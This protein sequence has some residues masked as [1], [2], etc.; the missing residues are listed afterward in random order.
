MENHTMLTDLYQLTMA[1]SYHGNNNQEEATFDMFIRKLPKDRNYLI[2]A[3]LEQVIEYL[4]NLHFTE[5]DIQYLREQQL[6][7]EDFLQ[8]LKKFKFEGEVYAVQEGTPIFDNEPIMRITAP[9]I[10]AQIVETFILNTI[11][12]QTMIA[13]KASRIVQTANPQKVVDFGLRRA[14][15][16]D[17]GMKAARASYIAGCVA[18]SNVKAGKQYSMPISGTMAHSYIMD[19]E[20]ELEAFR[21]YAKT[22]KNQPKALTLLIDTYD[23]IQGAKNAAIIAKELEKEGKKIS[24]VRLDSGDL[25]KLS[26][27]VRKILDEQGLNY[28]KIFASNDLNEYKIK[29]LQ[30]QG[31]KIDAYGVG[32][33]MATS[34]DHPALP[35][36]YKLAE[37][38]KNGKKI[39][40][41]KLSEDKNTMP[42]RK[43][44]YRLYSENGKML[45]DI[46][47]LETE[48]IEGEPLLQKVMQNGKRLQPKKSLGKIRSYCLQQVD[49]LPDELK[50]IDAK[51][52]YK[53][54]IAPGLQQ[55]TQELIK[56]YGG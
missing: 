8:Y 56:K 34:K 44:A 28:V 43:Q 47:A 22:F 17:A 5:E 11:N 13:S 29:Q 23:T 26:I 45:N 35:G 7:T 19:E 14:H 3:G 38:T 46:I 30:E 50:K 25:T 6:F 2:A 51:T 55:L 20:T 15:G 12:F 54:G 52:N 16:S 33:E 21:N 24:A 40:R 1:A 42:G 27:E 4:E 37:T 18:T 53:V 48:K 36:V 10:Q 41:M 49:K 32:T 31:A 39:P 9:K